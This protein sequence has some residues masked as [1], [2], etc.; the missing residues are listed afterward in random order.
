VSPL[1]AL[2]SRKRRF[3]TA[4]VMALVMGT[5]VFT[6]AGAAWRILPHPQPLE[7][8]SYYPSGRFL[9]PATLGHAA[10]AADL[11]WLRAVQYYGQHRTS[12]NQYVRMG[13]VFDILTALDP[14]FVPAY[15]FGAFALAQEGRDFPAAERLMKQGLAANPT[16]GELAFQMGFLYYVRPGGRDLKRAAECF[17]QASRQPDGPPES[18]RFAAFSRQNAGDLEV[19]Y[20]L[21]SQVERSSPNLYLREIAQR[22]MAR[23]REALDRGHR[24]Q[25]MRR[26]TTPVVLITGQP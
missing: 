22:E 25:A 14:A 17:E 12:D 9:E 19:A 3:L 4:W 26:L 1:V 8:L 20:E 2:D 24:E 23:I 10:T 18:A 11:A 6:L 5:A 13:H 7:E 16:S 21:W 15:V